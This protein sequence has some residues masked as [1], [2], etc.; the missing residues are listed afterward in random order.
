MQ[1]PVDSPGLGIERRVE[2]VSDCSPG[3]VAARVEGVE[4]PLVLRGLVAEW[5]LVQRSRESVAAAVEYVTSFYRGRPVSLFLGE[6]DIEGRFFYNDS[7][8]GFNFL[9]MEAKLT[10]VLA[11]L[12]EAQQQEDAPCF[13]VGSTAVDQWLPGFSNTNPMPLPGIDPLTSIWIGNRSRVA[14]HFDFPE[15]IA[16]CAL[17]RRRFTV[18]PPEQVANLYVGPMDLTPAGQQISLVDFHD[19]DF[20][21]FPR[22]KQALEAALV[23]E[24]EPGDALFLPGVWWHHVEALDPV[25]I[26][27]NYWWSLQPESKGSPAD[28]LSHALLSI[29][30]LPP[31]QR[32]AWRALFDYYV[33][34]A[35]EEACGHIPEAARG[36]LGDIDDTGT[37]RLRAELLNQLKR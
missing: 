13:Y 2:E 6:A 9:Q 7:L 16:C 33:F 30:S 22:F 28:A 34:E 31:A 5:P 23:A 24:L 26:L 20:E 32:H 1:I 37:R 27:V 3:D 17:G 11:K 15:N 18:F 4:H 35:P 21:R 36:R 19:P 10:D 14:A 29:K 25:N 12:L 8:S